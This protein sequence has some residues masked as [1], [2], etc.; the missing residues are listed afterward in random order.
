MLLRLS[1]IIVIL[2]L[3]HLSILFSQALL[4]DQTELDSERDH[5]I[6]IFQSSNFI[7]HKEAI[8]TLSW[9]G[10]SDPAIY[11]LIL[12]KFNALIQ[13]QS[14]AGI[15]K[16]AWYAKGLG[17][18]GNQKY[19]PTL[20]EGA[21]QAAHKKVR[22]Y[23]A[24]GNEHL[25]IYTVWNP[26][27]AKDN[28]SAP[29]GQLEQVRVKNMIESSDY[30]L[31]RHGTKYVYNH[32]SKNPV[33]VALV[34]E[35]L[36]MEYKSADEQRNKGHQVDAVAWM[37]KVLAESE[38]PVNKPAIQEIVDNTKPGKIQKYAKKY[39]NYL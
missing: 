10:I 13:D 22:K 8:E 14:K 19:G 12:E 24:K 11:D 26:I 39:V 35:R 30:G 28:E 6:S 36:L 7:Q 3:A 20:T 17:R 2:S 29:A 21:T 37:I 38:D 16:A 31:L 18:S 33:M 25:A 32:H 9:T 27:I 4:A 23:S 34:R 5:Y 1:K 15:E